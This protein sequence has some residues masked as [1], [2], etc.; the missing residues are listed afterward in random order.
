MKKITFSLAALLLLIACNTASDETTV[1]DS[2][3]TTV[4]TTAAGPT[5]TAQA[6]RDLTALLDSMNSAFV[7]GDAGFVDRYTAKD[8]VYM[9]TDPSEVWTFDEYRRYSDQTF[10]DTAFKNFTF[11]VTRREIRIHG[12]SANLVEQYYAPVYSKKLMF[13][14]VAHARYENGRWLLDMVT[15]NAIPKNEDFPKMEKVL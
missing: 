12:A 15:Y 10:K 4:T 14:T 5:D 8:G 11:N 3:D 2:E 13:R 7:R 1:T 9:G 6:R